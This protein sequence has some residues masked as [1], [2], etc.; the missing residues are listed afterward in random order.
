MTNQSA[1]DRN[2]TILAEF[3][4]SCEEAAKTFEGPR[5]VPDGPPV[6]ET[7]ED[8]AIP[9]WPPGFLIQNC[10]VSAVP[11][12]RKA[13]E[14]RYG[15][16]RAEMDTGLPNGRALESRVVGFQHRPTYRPV[17]SALPGSGRLHAVLV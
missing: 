2:V 3:G 6:V 16:R 9:V 5:T 14:K 7:G 4:G 8:V 17:T 10:C 15:A 13:M 12:V 11:A 1:D